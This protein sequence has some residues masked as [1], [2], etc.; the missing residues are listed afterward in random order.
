MN[1]NNLY[2]NV[3]NQSRIVVERDALLYI[4][5]KRF[6]FRLKVETSAKNYYHS[7]II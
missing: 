3:I 6:I 1:N 5:Y 2:Y 7:K 4:L